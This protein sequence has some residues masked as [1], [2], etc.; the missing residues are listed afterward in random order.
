M[1]YVMTKVSDKL[2]RVSYS[3][4]VNQYENGYMVEVSG[5]N[6]DDEYDTYRIIAP[7]IEELVK[8]VTEISTM[9]MDR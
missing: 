8:L 6:H 7:T 4:T 1:G 5:R 2:K 3:Y 9:D